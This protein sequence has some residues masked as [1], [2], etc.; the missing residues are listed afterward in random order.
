MLSE[1]KKVP[2][3]MGNERVIN[4]KSKR[5]QKYDLRML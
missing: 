4:V 5:T 2:V 1:H 3:L